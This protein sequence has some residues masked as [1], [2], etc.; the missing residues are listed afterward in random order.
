VSR[1][2]KSAKAAFENVFSAMVDLLNRSSRK[3]GTAGSTEA[4]A[5][6]ALCIGGMVVA[7]AI[8]DR[9]IADDLRTACMSVALE[10]GGWAEA[11]A[12]RARKSTKPSTRYTM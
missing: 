3:K 4:K 1:S 9:A 2:G 7:R 11:N 6:A 8:E 10:L 12:A 5:I